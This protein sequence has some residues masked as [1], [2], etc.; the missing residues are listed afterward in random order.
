MR[1]PGGGSDAVVSARRHRRAVAGALVASDQIRFFRAWLADP[2]RVGG[3][4]PSSRALA[5]AMTAEITPDLAPILELGPGTGVF[6][7][8]LIERGIP[9]DQLILVERHPELV[10]ILRRRFPRAHVL[11]RDAAQPLTP[12]T[13]EI[14]P[15]GAALSGLPVLS[16]PPRRP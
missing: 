13:A 2:L 4:V 14:G 11:L 10:E 5:L 6:T 16:M 15:V 3:M 7:Q 8:A 12:E 9:E 1:R